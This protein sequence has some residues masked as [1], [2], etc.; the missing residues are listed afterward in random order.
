VD[1]LR[2]LPS[3]AGR[4]ADPSFGVLW[5]MGNTPRAGGERPSQ[6]IAAIGPR[7]GSTHVK[8]AVH[9]P[10]HPQAAEDGWRDVLPGTGELPLAESIGRLHAIGY[11]GWLVFEHEKRWQPGLPDPETAFPAYAAWVRGVQAR[12]G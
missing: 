2:R 11:D 4:I 5:D 6:T 3:P 7:I 10:R 8:D 1:A 9:D 12:L